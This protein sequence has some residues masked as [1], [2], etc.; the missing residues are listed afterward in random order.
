LSSSEGQVVLEM[1]GK[2]VWKAFE[3]ESGKHIVQRCPPTESKGRRHTSVIS[4]AVLS[5]LDESSIDLD[6]SE[7]SV[8]TKR[9][10]GPGGQHKNTTDSAVC[11]THLPTGIS[12]N[13]DGRCQHTNR[14]KA[15]AILAAKIQQFNHAKLQ[16]EYAIIKKS[17]RK[18]GNR[19]DKIRTYNFIRNEAKDH[20][21]GI[22]ACLKTFLKGK[23]DLLY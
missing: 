3:H 7:V 14:K 18:K 1:A 15:L 5:P 10:K 4:V 2:G 8:K 19:S 17:Q 20:R 13:I 12:V 16:N 11:A 6:L 23:I 9:G 22:T 21:T